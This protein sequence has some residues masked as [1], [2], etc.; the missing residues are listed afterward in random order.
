MD[1]ID[2]ENQ[3]VIIRDLDALHYIWTQGIQLKPYSAFPQQR[4]AILAAVE[5][6]RANLHKPEPTQ[7]ETHEP[8]D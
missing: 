3:Q 7:E 1:I 5:R 8:T 2:I 4:A 6:K